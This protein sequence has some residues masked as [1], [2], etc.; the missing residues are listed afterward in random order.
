MATFSILSFI[1]SFAYAILSGVAQGLQPL[2]G[3]A[4]GAKDDNL[5][6]QY[7]NSGIKI[8][9]VTSALILIFLCIFDTQTVGIFT[10]D[11]ELLNMTSKAL[12]IFVLSFLFMAINLI[13]TAYFYSTKQ[14]I[15]SGVIVLSRGVVIKA[16]LTFGISYLFGVEYMWH[17]VLAAETITFGIC[18]ICKV[19]KI[20]TV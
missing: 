17:S 11:T 12:S 5:L 4:F 8:N 20:N 14:T 1:Y 6:K 18:L 19:S 2:W 3:H 13:F 7:F 9:F 16:L 15:K 10:K